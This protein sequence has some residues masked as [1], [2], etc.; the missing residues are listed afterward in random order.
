M[1]INHIITGIQ[2]GDS[3]AFVTCASLV[4]YESQIK[5][6]LRNPPRDMLKMLDLVGCEVN[7]NKDS[8]FIG[9]ACIAYREY[10]SLTLREWSEV[11]T[12]VKE[13][14]SNRKKG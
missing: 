10:G 11:E 12:V 8:L 6:K 9:D 1:T 4:N 14:K 7:G 3:G 13:W 2:R 5:L